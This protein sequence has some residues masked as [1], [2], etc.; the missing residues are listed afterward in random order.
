[1]ITLKDI[2]KANF[3][4][5]I[6]Y[7]PKVNKLCRRLYKMVSEEDDGIT[8]VSARV[9]IPNTTLGQVARLMQAETSKRASTVGYARTEEHYL[10]IKVGEAV[11]EVYCVIPE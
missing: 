10:E 3:A 8:I 7:S 1:M 5:A 6:G 9:S 11:V 4:T 2:D